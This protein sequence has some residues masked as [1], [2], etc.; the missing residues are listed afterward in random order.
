M[1]ITNK[2]ELKVGKTYA[3]ASNDYILGRYGGETT[4]QCRHYGKWCKCEMPPDTEIFLFSNGQHGKMIFEVG[5]KEVKNEFHGC[6]GC[7]W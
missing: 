4:I 1:I 2:N 7:M 6:T 3:Y 5:L